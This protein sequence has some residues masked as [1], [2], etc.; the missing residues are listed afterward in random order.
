MWQALHW[1]LCMYQILSSSQWSCYRFHYEL[2]M[3]PSLKRY[4]IISWQ[5]CVRVHIYSEKEKNHNK[6]ANLK[7]LT[8]TTNISLTHKIPQHLYK[9]TASLPH[10]S[11]M[12]LLVSSISINIQNKSEIK[13][14]TE[15]I[16][17]ILKWR[18]QCFEL[19]NCVIKLLLNYMHWLTDQHVGGREFVTGALVSSGCFVVRVAVLLTA[20]LGHVRLYQDKMQQI[21]WDTVQN[22][23]IYTTD[24]FTFWCPGSL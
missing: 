2:F 5:K 8:N 18:L 11:L 12:I 22:L 21:C 4:T 7:R 23:G 13:E 6:F 14:S 17:C 15:A 24:N 1:G 3:R 9:L 16:K 10:L 20:L 19:H